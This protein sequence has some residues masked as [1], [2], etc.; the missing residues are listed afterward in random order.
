[1][2]ATSKEGL[3]SAEYAWTHAPT[4]YPRAVNLM[5]RARDDYDAALA[6]VD[7]LVMPTTLTPANRLP[8]PGCSLGESSAAAAG[9]TDNTCQFNGTGHP[10]LAMPIGFVPAREDAAV[11]VPASMQIVGRFWDEVRVLTVAYAWEQMFDW[12]KF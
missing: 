8:A 3:I 4:V 11:R 12:K 1:M 10:A 6:A 9:K 5:R 2:N 7:V